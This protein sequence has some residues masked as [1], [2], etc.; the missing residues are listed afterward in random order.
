MAT[1]GRD[2]IFVALRR[3]YRLASREYRAALLEFDLTTRQAEALLA[4]RRHPGEGVRILADAVDIDLPTCSVIV[5]KLEA[6]DLITRQPDPDDRRR[7]RL[8][9]TDAA[10]AVLTHVSAARAAADRRIAAALGPDAGALLVLLNRLRDELHATP[11]A[12]GSARD[13][14]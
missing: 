10:E 9:V 5:A 4:V 7:T 11:V 13:D 8:Y 14:A 6:R 12:A 2:S 1:R 3:A